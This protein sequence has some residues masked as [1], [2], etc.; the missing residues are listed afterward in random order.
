MDK[1]DKKLD[2]MYKKIYKLIYISISDEYV[3][4]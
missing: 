1:I 2:T 4:Y 3:K